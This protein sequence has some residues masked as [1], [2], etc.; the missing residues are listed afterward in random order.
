MNCKILLLGLICMLFASCEKRE[1]EYAL[2]VDVE[3]SVVDT[4]SVYLEKSDYAGWEKVGELYNITGTIDTLLCGQIREPGVIKVDFHKTSRPV[5]LV[6]N[7]YTTSIRVKNNVIIISGRGEN[8]DMIKYYKARAELL[9]QQYNVRLK[10]KTHINDT[11]LTK[12]IERN[13]YVQDSV[14]Q[15]S[16][17]YLTT[18]ALNKN[19]ILSRVLYYNLREK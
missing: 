11:T 10:H 17:N 3:N 1:K 5:Y 18:E 6:A 7:D 4:L 13:L 19:E 12:E 15:D 9:K 14:L 8:D 2:K 16:I